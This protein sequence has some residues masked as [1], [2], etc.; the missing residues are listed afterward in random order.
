MGSILGVVIP[1]LN[2]HIAHSC[3]IIKDIEANH[4]LFF[5]QNYYFIKN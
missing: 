1:S 4:R 3:H 2:I 5:L